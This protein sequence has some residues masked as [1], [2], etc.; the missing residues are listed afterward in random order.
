MFTFQLMSVSI[1]FDSL[2]EISTFKF[3]I[4]SQISENVLFS[5]FK[6]KTNPIIYNILLNKSFDLVIQ[7]KYF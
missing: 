4:S 1:F 2:S 7:N 3:K 6:N 5:I